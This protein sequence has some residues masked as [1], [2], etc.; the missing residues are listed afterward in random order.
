MKQRGSNLAALGP[1]V[2]LEGISLLATI[3]L[4]ADK[5]RSRFEEVTNGS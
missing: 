3:G 4:L 2:C 1:L 5:I